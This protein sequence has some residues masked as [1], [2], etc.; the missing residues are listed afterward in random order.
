[1]WAP[2]QI[3]TTDQATL[4]SDQVAT[5]MVSYAALFTGAREE[6]G[7]IST[8]KS[9]SSRKKQYDTMVATFY[10]LVTDFYEYGWGQSFH[11]APRWVG[12]SFTASIARAEHFLALKLQ[13]NAKDKVLDMGCGIGGPMR[14]IARFAQVEVQGVTINAYQVQVGNRYNHEMGLAS[15]CVLTEG[16]FMQMPYA[17]DTFHAAYAIE[18]T[19]HAPDKTKAFAEAFRVLQPG[20]LF[21][22]YEWMMIGEYDAGNAEHVR[23]KEGIEVGNGLP[24]LET[25]EMLTMALEAAGFEVVEHFDANAGRLDKQQV[26]WYHTLEGNWSLQ[27]FRTSKLGQYCTHFMVSTLEFLKIAPKGSV[28]VHNMLIATAQDLVHAGQLGIMTPSYYFLAR[29]PNTTAT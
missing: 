16:D 3:L 11:F 19:C 7:T 24:T 27:G 2:T 25:P 13:L 22:G 14:S 9:I 28:R 12:E 4:S 18:S 21:S 17:N 15:Q 10:D 26:P 6:V 1:M 23:L 29:K 8:S 5:S 20:G